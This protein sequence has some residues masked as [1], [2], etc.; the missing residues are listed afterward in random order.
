M[1]TRNVTPAAGRRIHEP[2]RSA[3]LADVVRIIR[4]DCPM[5]T[6]HD[7]QFLSDLLRDRYR[8]SL[9]VARLCDLSARCTTNRG[10]YALANWIT[11]Q[12]D[13]RCAQPVLPLDVALLAQD[14]AQ[15]E[16]DIAERTVTL[17]RD[18]SRTV[19]ELAIEKATANARALSDWARSLAR[20]LAT[21]ERPEWR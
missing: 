14:R 19:L 9:A 2:A 18:P 5:L 6:A 16:S 20:K 7:Q 17:M 21:V 12:I 13:G 8:F 4:D 15:H 10:R 1:T 11:Q 3:G